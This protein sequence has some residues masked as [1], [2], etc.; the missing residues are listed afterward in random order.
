MIGERL[1]R[2]FEIP[3]IAML[4]LHHEFRDGRARPSGPAFGLALTPTGRVRLALV[5]RSHRFRVDVIEAQGMSH[6]VPLDRRGEFAERP[7]FHAVE[8]LGHRGL[9]DAEIGGDLILRPAE[10]GQVHGAAFAR[11]NPRARVVTVLPA[12]ATSTA[13]RQA[14]GVLR[15][16]ARA[17][18]GRTTCWPVNASH[19]VTVA[20]TYV[21]SIS[22]A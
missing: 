12:T 17:D 2:Y 3:G 18:R 21:G 22:I 20:W 11:A 15:L 10:H 8:D 1:A 7:S 9:G 6:L 19:R 4:V 13:R 14:H 5:P 16:E